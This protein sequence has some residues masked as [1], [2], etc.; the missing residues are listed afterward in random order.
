MYFTSQKTQN[1]RIACHIVLTICDFYVIIIN[2]NV[3]LIKNW[4]EKNNPNGKS[5]LAG[6]SNISTGTL[7][8][9]L[10]CGHEPGLDI[11]RRMAKAIGVSLDEIGNPDS[12]A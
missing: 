11:A 2:M 6:M 1:P 5:R 8:K 3:T 10:N 4:I 12:V 9:I 7:H